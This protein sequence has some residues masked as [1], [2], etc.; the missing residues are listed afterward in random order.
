MASEQEGGVS[1]LG[2]QEKGGNQWSV[3]TYTNDGYV[4]DVDNV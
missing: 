1:R 2:G 3:L 4:A